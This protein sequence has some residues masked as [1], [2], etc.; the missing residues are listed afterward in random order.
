[1]SVIAIKI[2]HANKDQLSTNLQQQAVA[3]KLQAGS[4]EAGFLAAFCPVN[5]TPTLVVI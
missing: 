1:V 4:Q 5:S 2:N 3:L